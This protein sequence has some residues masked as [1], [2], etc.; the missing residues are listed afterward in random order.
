M[1][2][3]VADLQLRRSEKIEPL[4]VTK[5][6][7]VAIVGAGPAGLTAAHDL[8]HMGYAVTVFE[9]LPVAG[10]MMVVGIPRIGWP[11]AVVYSITSSRVYMMMG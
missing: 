4:P 2:R 11:M 1:K 8:R 7:K 10:G 6:E 9:E 3:F 5:D